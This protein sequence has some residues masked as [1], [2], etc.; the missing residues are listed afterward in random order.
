MP[1]TW[2]QG[3]VLYHVY[4]RSFRDSIGDL[5]GITEQLD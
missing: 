2:R 4:P 5:P 3:S 1:D